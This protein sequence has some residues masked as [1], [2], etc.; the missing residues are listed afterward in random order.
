[1]ALRSAAAPLRASSDL[2]GAGATLRRVERVRLLAERTRLAWR[3]R[4]L[5]EEGQRDHVDHEGDD[6]EDDH[7]VQERA[8]ADS[9]LRHVPRCIRVGADT[10]LKHDLQVAEVDPSEEEPDGRH[11]DVVDQRVD[12]PAERC[13]DDHADRQRQSV[14]L[15][16]EGLEAGEVPDHRLEGARDTLT[17]LSGHG[18]SR[19]RRMVRQVRRLPEAFRRGDRAARGA[20]GRSAWRHAGRTR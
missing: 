19:S 15:E 3:R 14:R 4:R 6:D 1:V 5:R 8:I 13:A 2:A 11:D 17:R 9:H 18:P 12:D 10:R 7:Q 16:Q 20:P